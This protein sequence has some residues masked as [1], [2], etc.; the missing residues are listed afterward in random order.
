ML[1]MRAAV[2]GVAESRTRLSDWTEFHI[3]VQYSSNLSFDSDFW[4]RFF[5]ILI[6]VGNWELSLSACV[7]N[8][9]RIHI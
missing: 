6:F 5:N 7:F 3:L 1:L 9:L 4:V 8:I 2:H